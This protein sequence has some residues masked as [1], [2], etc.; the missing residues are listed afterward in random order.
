MISVV[1]VE[2]WYH[3]A[4]T[5]IFHFDGVGDYSEKSSMAIWLNIENSKS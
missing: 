3:A 4:K 1:Y 2:R 5:L